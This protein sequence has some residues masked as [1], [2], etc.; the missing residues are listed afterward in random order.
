MGAAVGALVG[1]LVSSSVVGA[2]VGAC[3]GMCVGESEF[4][5]L[6]ASVGLRVGVLVVLS[7]LAPRVKSMRTSQTPSR[8][9]PLLLSILSQP[10]C[11]RDDAY[12]TIWRPLQERLPDSSRC[13]RSSEIS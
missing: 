13:R 3:V 2:T 5:E 7:A 11:S 9:P 4:E 8:R 10:H 12:Y 6:G 1:E